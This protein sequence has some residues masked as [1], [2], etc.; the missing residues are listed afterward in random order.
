M[1][2]YHTFGL[3]RTDTLKVFLNNFF[4]T[5]SSFV[6]WWCDGCINIKMTYAAP[7]EKFAL[8]IYIKI[9]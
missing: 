5:Y 6:R 8:H 7:R 4:S 2:S 1:S 9:K 3:N